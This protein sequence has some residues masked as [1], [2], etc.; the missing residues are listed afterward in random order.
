MQ[1]KNDIKEYIQSL[2]SSKR[3]GNLVVYHTVLPDHPAQVS[4]PEKPWPKI[5]DRI[6]Q[7]AGIRDLYRHQADAI[8]LIRSGRH[9]VVA[10][11]TASGKTLI[12]NLPVV[13]NILNN[14]DSKALY[15]FPLKAL[16]QDQI[17]TFKTL[18]KYSKGE[19]PKIEIY[20]GDTSAWHRKRI[21]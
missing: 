15:I 18:M 6:I 10:T 4:K 7:S 17:R 20:D 5:I 16:A 19:T 14:P 12:Y 11:P 21:R 3:M 13:E 9:V 2:L 1:Q 8:D